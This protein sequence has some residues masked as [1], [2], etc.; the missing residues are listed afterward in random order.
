MA[1]QNNSPKYEDK[2]ESYITGKRNPMNVFEISVKERP[3]GFTLTSHNVGTSAYVSKTHAKWRACLPVN[4]KLLKVNECDVEMLPIE[5]ICDQI[6]NVDLP[7]TLTFCHP[8]GLYKD[9]LPDAATVEERERD[10]K[11]LFMITLTT[12]PCGFVLTSGDDGTGVYVT[13]SDYAALPRNS[14]LLKSSERKVELFNLNDIQD[15]INNAE[16]PLTLTF[17]H[18]EGLYDDEKANISQFYE[19]ITA[20]NAILCAGTW[21]TICKLFFCCNYY[22]P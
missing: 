17:C 20:R 1:D 8:D 22:Q 18:P 12:R 3:L 16:L 15:I 6:R 7:F 13:E 2:S 9:E 5:K 21:G 4:C 11:C 10:P 19:D 14:K